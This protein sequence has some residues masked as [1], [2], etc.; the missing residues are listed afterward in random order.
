MITRFPILEFLGKRTGTYLL[1]DSP[2]EIKL[3]RA[4]YSF[5]L[6]VED[7]SSIRSDFY[8]LIAV[9][10]NDLELYSSFGLPNVLSLRWPHEFKEIRSTDLD[11]EFS[12]PEHNMGLTLSFRDDML[13][14]APM[15]SGK[16]VSQYVGKKA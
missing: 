7:P 1:P 9:S 8:G 5:A 16:P 12:H 14:F 15:A 6:Q 10:D 4:G 3:L 13:T 11:I 2:R